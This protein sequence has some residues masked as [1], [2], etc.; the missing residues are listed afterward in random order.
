MVSFDRARL[1]PVART[2]AVISGRMM[3][4]SPVSSNMMIT[5]VMGARAAPA[6]TAPIPISPYAPTGPAMPGA[7]WWAVSPNAA[8]SM[9]PMNSEGAK[10]PPEPPMPMVRL[11]AAIL[12]TS[13]TTR[14]PM[15]YFPPTAFSSTG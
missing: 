11:V 7:T 12:P 13:S 2:I 1:T 3:V 4:Y 6:K 10:T 14:K 8:P 5:A 15:T 9:A